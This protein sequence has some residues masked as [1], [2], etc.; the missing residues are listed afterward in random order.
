MPMQRLDRQSRTL[1]LDLF[2]PSSPPALDWRC[3][4]TE[5]REKVTRLM[6]RMLSAHGD[7]GHADR[8]DGGQDD[9]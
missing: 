4:P 8:T 3:L 6:A 1:Q 7:P 2:R 9:E 5:V